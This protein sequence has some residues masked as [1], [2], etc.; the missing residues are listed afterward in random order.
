MY[1]GIQQANQVGK[2]RPLLGSENSTLIQLSEDGA[3]APRA[4]RDLMLLCETQ[5]SAF[6]LDAQPSKCQIG[7]AICNKLERVFRSRTPR[8]GGN[9]S[10]VLSAARD[11]IHLLQLDLPAAG[12]LQRF[13][14]RCQPR[15]DRNS[16]QP[17]SNCIDR[18]VRKK[19]VSQC[20]RERRQSDNTAN[21]PLQSHSGA[22]LFRFVGGCHVCLAA[23]ARIKP[24]REAASA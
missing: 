7:V 10:C 6:N 5:Q 22:F 12:K 20:E 18:K 8:L 13:N 4:E 23:N 21:T 3:D 11:L 14:E 1:R 24:R 2:Y 15:D 17:E 16:E 9:Q 19:Q